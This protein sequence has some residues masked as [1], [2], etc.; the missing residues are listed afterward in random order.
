MWLS[1]DVFNSFLYITYIDVYKRITW[2]HKYTILFRKKE[3]LI[4]C[5]NISFTHLSI[6]YLRIWSLES[7]FRVI[8]IRSVVLVFQA[9]NSSKQNILRKKMHWRMRDVRDNLTRG[10]FTINLLIFVKQ[11]KMYQNQRV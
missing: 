1:S 3:V 10:G 9:D 2:E 11:I 7:F 8:L 5:K 4:V 6:H